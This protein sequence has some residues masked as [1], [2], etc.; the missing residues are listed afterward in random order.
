MENPL[1]YSVSVMHANL[2]RLENDLTALEAAGCGELH[3]GV[4]DGHFAPGF[5]PGFETIEAV[6]ACCGLPCAAHLM[7]SDPGRYIERFAEAG[8]SSITV[9]VEACVHAHRVLNQIR[10]AGVSPG[11]AINP[12]TPLTKLDYLLESADRVLLMTREPGDPGPPLIRAAFERIRLLN[13]N[14]RYRK[15]G[16]R[17]EAG[18]ELD[19]DHAAL[20]AN[21]G[22]TI[23]ECGR[24]AIFD[25]RNPGEALEAFRDAVA[26][27]RMT[28]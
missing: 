1:V 26:A 28:V 6:R 25:G 12:A 19:A 23:I 17:I 21:A 4:M 14:L 20:V 5:G 22:A 7:V 2:V 18:G 3:F 11:I 24:T 27:R 9:H 13:E 8:C 10:D 16:T 15:L